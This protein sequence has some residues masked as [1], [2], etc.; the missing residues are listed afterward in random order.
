VGDDG[1]RKRDVNA[2]SNPVIFRD[3]EEKK[4]GAQELARMHGQAKM[5]ACQ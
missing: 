4:K 3:G 1:R 2:K 5:R